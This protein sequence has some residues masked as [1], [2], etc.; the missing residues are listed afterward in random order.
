MEICN[1][2]DEPETHEENTA[3]K[4]FYQNIVGKLNDTNT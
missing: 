4:E 1:C 3:F 2:D